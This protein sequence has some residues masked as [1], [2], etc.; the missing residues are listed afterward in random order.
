VPTGGWL[1]FVTRV[2]AF[3]RG[4]H[5]RRSTNAPIK[6]RCELVSE[7]CGQADWP[8]WCDNALAMM[9]SEVTA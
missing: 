7:I 8:S 2:N 9:T 5:R 3:G 4:P 6:R 1:S